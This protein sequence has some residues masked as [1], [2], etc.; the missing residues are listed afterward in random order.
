MTQFAFFTIKKGGRQV[1]S[2]HITRIHFLLVIITL[3]FLLNTNQCAATKAFANTKPEN[4]KSSINT[5]K[6]WFDKGTALIKS[7]KYKEAIECF[8]KALL[9]CAGSP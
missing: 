1:D 6:D 2:D 8:D 3:T 7:N 9:F 4:N 5:A